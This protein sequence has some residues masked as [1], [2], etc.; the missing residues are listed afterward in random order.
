MVTI[1]R[2]VFLLGE[3]DVK[4]PAKIAESFAFRS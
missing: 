2:G 4:G 1:A 3:I